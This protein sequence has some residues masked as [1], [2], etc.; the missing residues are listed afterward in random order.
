MDNIL[1]HNQRSVFYL[2]YNGLQSEISEP[3]GWNNTKLSVELALETNT[4]R[5]SFTDKEI[6]LRFAEASGFSYLLGI[7]NTA[8]P[9]AI[10]LLRYGILTND[11]DFDQ[12]YEGRIVMAMWDDTKMPD[13]SR[14][15]NLKVERNST[16][17][18]FLARYTSKTVI[19]SLK[20]FSGAP[21]TPISQVLLRLHQDGIIK[22]ASM[23]FNNKV[24]KTEDVDGFSGFDGFPLDNYD[25]GGKTFRSTVPPD[26]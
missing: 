15:A 25:I 13:A 6:T 2:V 5:V 26:H 17:D 20:S 21:L 3:A 14:C 19:E 8:G 4:Y 7:N 1:Y 24:L 9:D 11:T 18:L 22:S 16:A 23:N 12:L 10:A